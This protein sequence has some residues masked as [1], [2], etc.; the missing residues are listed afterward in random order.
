MS[1]F[2]ENIKVNGYDLFG[3]FGLRTVS[4]EQNNESVFGLDRSVELED[5]VDNPIFVKN[6]G[7][8]PSIT[9][10]LA[11][12]DE[13]GNVPSITDRELDEIGRILFKDGITSV[14][15]KGLIYYGV[16]TKGSSFFNGA[17]QGYLTLT[18]S[19]VCNYPYSRINVNPVLVKGDKSIEIYNKSTS[20]EEIYLD[21]TIEQLG[22]NPITVKN[23]TINDYMTFNNIEL[24]EVINVLGE[25]ALE[26]ISKTNPD[27]NIFNDL[28]FNSFIR[29]KYGRNVIEI[30]GDCRVDIK[31]QSPQIFK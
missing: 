24:N 29:L 8:Q 27:K 21:M 25:S 9:I 11:K 22:T 26:V 3:R 2:Y 20:K 4:V 10:Q 23:K 12:I 1:Q 7:N 6:K 15:H 13:N 16:F 19:M 28:E 31:Y 18:F 30:T 17:M 14:E 5:G